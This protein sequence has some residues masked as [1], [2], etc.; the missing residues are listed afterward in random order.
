MLL[1][2]YLTASNLDFSVIS[3]QA[4][5]EQDLFLNLGHV[6][7]LS[8]DL[9]GS[10]SRGNNTSAQIANP[11]TKYKIGIPNSV[12]LLDLQLGDKAY[13]CSCSSIG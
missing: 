8:I 2:Q 13:P 9:S 1:F 4:N 6:Q 5:L 11:A 7:N 10:V 3:E 12:F